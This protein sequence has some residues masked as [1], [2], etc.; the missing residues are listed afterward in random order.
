[1]NANPKASISVGSSGKARNDIA[2][3]T[4]NDLTPNAERAVRFPSQ[5]LRADSNR[6]SVSVGR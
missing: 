1:L 4:L 2:A 5:S 3:L 6:C